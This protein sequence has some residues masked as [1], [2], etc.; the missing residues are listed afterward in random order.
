MWLHL[1]NIQKFISHV[2]IGEIIAAPCAR[3]NYVT[4]VTIA[5]YK[6]FPT[7]CFAFH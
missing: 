7:A 6:E 4:P 5:Q 3:T 2:A 1:K